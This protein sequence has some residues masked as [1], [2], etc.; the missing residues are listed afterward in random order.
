[1][2]VVVSFESWVTF[3]ILLPL[4]P[5]KIVYFDISV[6]I[7]TFQFL[8]PII[9]TCSRRLTW[10]HGRYVTAWRTDARF[11]EYSFIHKF[12]CK[13][14]IQNFLT[15]TNQG[16][17][18]HNHVTPTWYQ[19]NEKYLTKSVQYICDKNKLAW[20]ELDNWYISKKLWTL[21]I[22]NN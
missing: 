21:K 7:S 17:R 22:D 20:V 5:K 8:Q 2:Q 4:P 9:A 16:L 1:M 19:L 14:N 10:K 6:V 15:A 12:S 3:L 13:R 11:A 18:L